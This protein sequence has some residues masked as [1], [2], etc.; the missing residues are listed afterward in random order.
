MQKEDLTELVGRCL[1]KEEKMKAS[2][3]LDQLKRLFNLYDAF[4]EATTDDDRW[5]RTHHIVRLIGEMKKEW[6]EN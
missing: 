3:R 2:K 6:E 5:R 1:M 4:K